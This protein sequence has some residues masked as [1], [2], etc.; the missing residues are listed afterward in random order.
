MMQAAIDRGL[1]KSA[2]A[3][4]VINQLH[5]E[6]KDKVAAGQAHMVEWDDIKANPPAELTI[7]PISMIPYKSRKYRTILD[8]LFSLWLQ[9]GGIVPS[10]NKASLKSA[11]AG[12]I[13]QIGHSLS[14]IIH[15]MASAEDDAK[16]LW[17]NGIS[18][19]VSGGLTVRTGRNGTSPMSSHRTAKQAPPLWCLIHYKWGG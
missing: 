15:A 6:V 4:D 9:N 17:Q 1:Y 3:P 2:L 16:I 19:T 18:R 7:S 11:P 8:L 12:A 13:D 14:W 5:Q 10:V